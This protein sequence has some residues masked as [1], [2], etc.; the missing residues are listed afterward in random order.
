MMPKEKETISLPDREINNVLYS[1]KK[2]QRLDMS[3]YSLET[4]T[5]ILEPVTNWLLRAMKALGTP[6]TSLYNK[7]ELMALEAM[8]NLLKL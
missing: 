8:N 1:H 3:V 5:C 6:P 4:Q 2:V 7:S